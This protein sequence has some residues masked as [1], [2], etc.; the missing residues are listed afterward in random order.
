ME[1]DLEAATT[2]NKVAK[3]DKVEVENDDLSDD[4]SEYDD[5]DINHLTMIKELPEINSETIIVPLL[6]KRSEVK[7]YMNLIKNSHLSKGKEA[8]T[9]ILSWILSLL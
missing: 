9:G 7:I 2:T 4:G 5:E 6:Y 1:E 3:N 8:Y